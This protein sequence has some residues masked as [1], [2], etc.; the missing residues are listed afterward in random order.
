MGPIWAIDETL[1]GTAT[2]DQS[3]SGSNGND[4]VFHTQRSLELE[5]HHQMQFS[6][7]LRTLFF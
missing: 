2:L 5:S 6:V 4:G 1:T 7:V 3:E